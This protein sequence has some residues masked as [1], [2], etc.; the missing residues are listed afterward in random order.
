MVQFPNLAVIQLLRML[1]IVPEKNII[2]LR[3]GDRL[4]SAFHRK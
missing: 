4:C 1:S 3:K 2:R